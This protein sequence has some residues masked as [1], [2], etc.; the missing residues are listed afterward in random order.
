[1]RARLWLII[2]ATAFISACEKLERVT[3]EFENYSQLV[4]AGEPGN[5]VPE[6]VPP[7]ARNIKESHLVDRPDLFVTFTI[8][9]MD[10][11]L[12][13]SHCDKIDARSVQL[14][15]PSDTKSIG[16]WPHELVMSANE[17]LLLQ[18]RFLFLRCE[19]KPQG[20]AA[21]EAASNGL[22]LFYWTANGR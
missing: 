19:G 5:W 15:S 17:G 12:I 7:S 1:M 11:H 4:A 18:S 13:L 20:F 14:P 16:W 6:F 8:D 22:Q 9:R 21:M 3:R 10:E 2:V